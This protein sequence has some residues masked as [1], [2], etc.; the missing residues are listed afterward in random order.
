MSQSASKSI[1]SILEIVG[2][3]ESTMKLSEFWYEI[4]QTLSTTESFI[5]T[6]FESIKKCRD[7]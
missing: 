4:F 3:V 1:V 2:L 6:L 5:L 7:N